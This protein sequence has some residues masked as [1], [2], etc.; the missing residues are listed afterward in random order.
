MK[1][2]MTKYVSPSTPTV[3][4]NLA[5][6]IVEAIL[7]NRHGALPEAAWRKGQP[8]A[9]EWGALLTK[10]RRVSRLGVSTQQLAWI[11]QFHKITDL[12]YK[13]FGLLRWKIQ[14]YFQWVNVDKFVAYYTQLQK[15][16]TEGSSD[17]VDETQGYKTKE[18]SSNRNKTLTEIL[19]ELE[20]G[21][22]DG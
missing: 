22:S 19:K 9:K 1:T 2:T 20:N 10:V 21:R 11:V 17:Y 14:K 8:F 15:T 12:D 4:H 3:K 16:L 13:E 7:M 5:N 6:F 18:K